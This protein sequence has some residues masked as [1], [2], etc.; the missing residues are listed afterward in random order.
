MYGWRLWS[1]AKAPTQHRLVSPFASASIVLRGVC[2]SQDHEVPHKGCDCGVHFVPN[3]AFMNKWLGR[4]GFRLP[5][6][7]V[8]YGIAYGPVLPDPT[9]APTLGVACAPIVFAYWRS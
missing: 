4:G 8:T 9:K 2:L 7:A 6:F 5:S 1:I 3:V